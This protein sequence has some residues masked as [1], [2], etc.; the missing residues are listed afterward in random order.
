MAAHSGTP[1]MVGIPGLCWHSSVDTVVL[2]SVGQREANLLDQHLG[3]CRGRSR[4]TAPSPLPRNLG[5]A[6]CRAPHFPPLKTQ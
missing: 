1:L 3:R 2:N 5:A 6:G 4:G